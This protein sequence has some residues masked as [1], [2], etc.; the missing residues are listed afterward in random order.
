MKSQ[1]E[2][3]NNLWSNHWIKS[4]L[5][6]FMHWSC[7]WTVTLERGLAHIT[8]CNILRFWIVNLLFSSAFF[9]W[10][11]NKWARWNKRFPDYPYSPDC[12]LK[13]TYCILF[14]NGHMQDF[15]L[16]TMLSWS[17]DRHVFKMYFLLLCTKTSRWLLSLADCGKADLLAGPWWFYWA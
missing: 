17:E 4:Q 9:A 8:F 10:S 15:T 5:S 16:W 13:Y 7:C 12:V 11:E 14:R 2:N 1:Q 3:K 6:D